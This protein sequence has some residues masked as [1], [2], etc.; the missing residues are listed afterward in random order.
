MQAKIEQTCWESS[1]GSKRYGV[2]F[3]GIAHFYGRNH[4]F[5]IGA[6]MFRIK[7]GLG[8]GCFTPQPDDHQALVARIDRRGIWENIACIPGVWTSGYGS[9]GCERKRLVAGVECGRCAVVIV[10]SCLGRSF[11]IGQCPLLHGRQIILVLK[12]GVQ[13]NMVTILRLQAC[14]KQE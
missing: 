4:L 9:A 14:A 7:I 10:H 1:T 12:E 8:T 13:V 6:G 5:I 2:Y 3:P 11:G